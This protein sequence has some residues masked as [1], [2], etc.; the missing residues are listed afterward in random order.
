[1]FDPNASAVLYIVYMENVKYC[2]TL[3]EM[4]QTPKADR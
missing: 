4:N 1:M 3:I 2:V